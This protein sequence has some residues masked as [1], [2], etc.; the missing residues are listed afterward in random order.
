MSVSELSASAQNYLKAVWGLQEWTDEPVTPTAL[1][2]KVGVRMSSVSDAVR[3]L[4]EQGLLTHTPYGAVELTEEGRRYAVA[5]V[6]R[7]RLIETFLVDVLG[8]TW[9]Q[10]HDEAETLEH[11][12]S[13]F[14]IDRIDE[15]LGQPSRDPHGDPIPSAEGVL[16]APDACLLSSVSP[17]ARVRVERISDADP[18]LLRFFADKDFRIGI[19]LEVREGAPF[20]GAVEVLCPDGAALALG[21]AATD[22]VWVTIEPAPLRRVSTSKVDSDSTRRG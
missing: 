12:V 19:E 3:R 22:A 21:Q 10:V 11:A 5:M 7:H 8:Y 1:A 15:R 6:R 2:A 9:D 16:D 17:G 14:M 20:S 4:S 13:D 18:E